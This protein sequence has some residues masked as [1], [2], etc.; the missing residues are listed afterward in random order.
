MLVFLLPTDPELEAAVLRA[1][2]SRPEQWDLERKE[3]PSGRAGYRLTGN[4]SILIDST[5]AKVLAG[6][7]PGWDFWEE[8]DG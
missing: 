6:Y 2:F 7:K 4:V 5:H 8:E 1:L 3:L